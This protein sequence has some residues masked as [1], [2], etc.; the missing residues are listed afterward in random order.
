MIEKI[1]IKKTKINLSDY[2]YKKDVK[3]RLL[4]NSFTSFDIDLLEEILY[5]S[6]KIPIEELSSSIGADINQVKTTL[7]KLEKTNLLT[8]DGDSILVD[9]K[10]R[11]YF[12]YQIL[13]YDEDFK[14]DVDYLLH[15]L[16]KVPI[17][18]LPLW[19]SIPKTT[20][21]IFKSIIDKYLITPVAFQRHLSELKFDPMSKEIIDMLFNSSEL[22]L[23]TK[24][25][26]EKY[27]LDKEKLEE[28]ILFLEFNFVC[29]KSFV[30]KGSEFIEV[31]IPFYEW[32]KY[33]EFFNNTKSVSIKNSSK[34]E[35]QN[36][37]FID[38]LTKLLKIIK[39]EPLLKSKLASLELDNFDEIVKSAAFL[40]FIKIKDEKL[41]ISE[42][43]KEWLKYTNEKK[44]IL[45]Y[46]KPTNQFINNLFSNDIAS[47]RNIREAEKSIYRILNSNWVYFDDFLKGITVSF[48]DSD[49]ITLK[50]HGTKW[51]YDLPKYTQIEI[52]F[53]Q[54]IF[55]KWFYQLGIISIGISDQKKCFCVTK[56]GQKIFEI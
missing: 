25:I 50:K 36:S 48:K 8:I 15:L 12:E 17:D 10:M 32:K 49:I 37:S 56:L 45:L 34:I 52:E 38:N 1:L 22:K 3:N 24:A 44:S 33:L 53:I 5:S 7:L 54:N 27:D 39:K 51:D 46:Q 11:K 21:D 26:A 4:M 20:N 42:N 28:L 6:L 31:L 43:G 18:I 40:N 14:P 29:C 19:Y 30:K 9:K 35:K 13:A 23:P 47:E 16:K 2:D 55:Y 41:S